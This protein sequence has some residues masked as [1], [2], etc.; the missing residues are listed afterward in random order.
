MPEN[1]PKNVTD[2][3]FEQEVLRAEGISV[4][5]FWAPWCG[6]CHQMAPA[7]EA[8]AKANEGRV[9]V[10]KMDSDDNP[11]TAEKYGVRSIPTVIFFKDGEPVDTNVGA[12]IHSALQSKLDGLLEK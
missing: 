7:L 3:Q 12:M 10:F 6:P 8:F 4:V 5:D 11:R 9:K 1:K 2:D